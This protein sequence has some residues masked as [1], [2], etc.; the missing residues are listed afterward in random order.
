MK[1][2][3]FFL[4][5]FLALA[6]TASAQYRRP[7]NYSRNSSPESSLTVGLAPL[8]L[9]L[10]SGK[11]NVRGEWAYADN[12]SIS[13]TIGI[14]RPTKAPGFVS[15][16]VST[17]E[18]GD[19]TTNRYTS[20]GAIVEHRF[21]FSHAAPRGFYLAPYARYNN[22]GIT[23]VTEHS[24]NSETTVKGRIGGAGIGGAAGVQFRMG[25]HFTMDATFAGIDFKWLR[26]TLT[27]STNNPEN[28]I[29]AFRDEVQAVVEDIPIIGSKLAAQI[30]G[31]K[32]KVHTPGWLLPGYR[33]N[34]TVNYAF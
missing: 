6:T 24:N 30:E 32:V 28:D 33:F 14:P 25:D 11:V 23:R 21:Y 29:A 8:S 18:G 17:D 5:A 2:I 3:L 4:P 20:F 27:Y 15:N 12:K 19:V 13:L 10:H 26:G 34:L 7:A 31:D 16:Q 22:F 9:L 1:S